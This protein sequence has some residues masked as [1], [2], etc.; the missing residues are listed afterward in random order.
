M[1]LIGI[2]QMTMTFGISM[3][4]STLNLFFRD[5]ERFI[6]LGIMLM[7]YCTPILYSGDM[8]PREYHFMIDFNPLA[9]MI[10]SW[11]DLFMNGVIDYERIAFLYG[12]AIFFV[13]VGVCIFNK[14]KYRF[15]EIL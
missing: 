7:F 14:L 11:R 1:P 3:M 6:T 2:A 12:Y 10:L 13:V 5:L 9:N 4:L 8:I 15:A